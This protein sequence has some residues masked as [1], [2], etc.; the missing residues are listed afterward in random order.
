M[1]WASCCLLLSAG[2]AVAVSG[3][4]AAVHDGSSE[5]PVTLQ[6]VLDLASEGSR[7]V[8]S[9]APYEVA[10]FDD[11]TAYAQ[12]PAAQPWGTRGRMLRWEMDSDTVVEVGDY[13]DIR[14]SPDRRHAVAVGEGGDLVLGRIA[15]QAFHPI[16]T[17]A[18]VT[19]FD[20]R[21]DEAGNT[22][23]WSADSGRLA[24]LAPAMTPAD[25]KG[26]ASVPV[27]ARSVLRMREIA[28][29]ADAVLF[30]PVAKLVGLTWPGGHGALYVTGDDGTKGLLDTNVDARGFHSWMLEISPQGRV[31]RRFDGPRLPALTIRPT[32][33]PNGAMLL[34]RRERFY[35]PPVMHAPE[36]VALDLRTGSE[37]ALPHLPGANTLRVRW[38]R[39]GAPWVACRTGPLLDSLCKL[40]MHGRL[41]AKIAGPV[42]EEVQR[43]APSPDSGRILW[44][45]LDAVGSFRLRLLEP[46]AD[47][48]RVLHRVDSL[49][50]SDDRRARVRPFAWSA[51]DGVALQGLLVLPQ[52]FRADRRYPL[53]VDVH[54]GPAPVTL[55]SA[56]V[57]SSP[58][59]WQMWSDKGYAVLVADYRESGAYGHEETWLRSSHGRFML[60][61]N[62]DDVLAG[63]AKVER[64]G[65]ADPARIALIG[66][67]MGA[68]VANQM[69]LRGERFA[70]VVSKEGLVDWTPAGMYERM[71]P[72]WL[73]WFDAQDR[74]SLQRMLRRHSLTQHLDQVRAPALFI[75]AIPPGPDRTA[76]DKRDAVDMAVRGIRLH[77]GEAEV[78]QLVDEQH[79][80][81]NLAHVRD[82]SQRVVEWV[83]RR[84]R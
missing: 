69:L 70:A 68:G 83:D 40:D 21:A 6:L 76:L 62:A 2:A 42:T 47:H 73:W 78:I 19:G 33:S 49:R 72:A 61:R 54:G 59:E 52:G 5:A 35:H 23:A 36:L 75:N 26:A 10:W 63:I 58:L 56:L 44:T 24:Y 8:V 25:A 43:F 27:P 53:I 84:V 65:I 37:A 39:D 64:L 29:G 16:D 28:T 34:Y 1:A 67:S 13:R 45:S 71:E 32:A 51:D 14:F 80:P 3:A 9:H 46:G 18:K 15:G 12:V 4:A 60:D 30:D 48:S 11:D 22:F 82:F 31:L 41:V 20:L 79:L 17:L 57:G 81:A 55:R 74:P 77:G 7:L 50:D 38:E 66:H